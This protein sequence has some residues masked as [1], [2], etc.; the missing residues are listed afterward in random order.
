MSK[1]DAFLSSLTDGNSPR[2]LLATLALWLIAFAGVRALMLPDEGRYVG[3]A[4]EM[5]TNGQWDVPRL[6]GLPFFHKPPLFYWLTALGLK[7][8]GIHDWSARF[9]SILAGVLTAGGLYLFARRHRNARVGAMA[10]LILVT[11]PFFFAGSQYANLDML[12]AGMISLTILAGAN[13]VLRIEQGL[14]YRGALAATYALAGLGVLAK[15]LIGI[16]LPGGVLFFWLLW[17]RAWRP[18]LKT[19]WPIGLLAFALVA[20][21]WFF[22][23]Q[24]LYPGFYD[25]FFI[26]H[27]FQRFAETGFNNQRPLWFY[28]PILVVFALPWTI[29]LTRLCNRAYWR[30]TAQAPL[31]SLMAIWLIV[32]VGFFSLPSS[33]LVGYVLPALAPLAYLIADPFADWLEREPQ[34]G[35]PRFRWLLGFAATACVVLV[36]AIAV[37]YTVSAKPLLVQARQSFDAETDD[38]AMIDWYQYDLPF[39][40][41][42]RKPAW[43][44]SRWSDPDIPKHDNWRKELFD[45][46]KFDPTAG[47]AQLIEEAQFVDRLCAR[48]RGAIW[49]WA[50]PPSMEFAL[51]LKDLPPTLANDRYALWRLTPESVRTLPVCAGKPTGG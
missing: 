33:K 45:A 18:L 42:T 48:Q 25:Y 30:D 5:V 9:A 50:R 41:R 21:P 14:P 7:L 39:Y 34:R 20:L 17:R 27:H 44:V 15:G 51:W 38:V 35:R 43:V 24:H 29:G 13:A 3:V 26:Y 16:V 37:G 28:V 47:T 1:I 31:R 12:V 46:A 2:R 49:V 40:L 6:D 22:W 10:S 11:S 19:L 23:M 32:I 36:A 4:W 8:F